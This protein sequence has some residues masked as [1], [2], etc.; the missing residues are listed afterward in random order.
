MRPLIVMAMLTL[1]LSRLSAVRSEPPTRSPERTGTIVKIVLATEA[2]KKEGILATITIK[3]KGVELP[4]PITADTRLWISKG[5]LGQVAKP[6]D[7]QVGE[8]V[9]VWFKEDTKGK[10]RTEQF[11][12]FRPGSPDLPPG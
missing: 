8:P 1:V 12:S 7:F 9:S 6:G 2:Q 5:K 10:I 3:D 4:V 11:M